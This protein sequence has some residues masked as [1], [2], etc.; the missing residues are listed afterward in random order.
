MKYTFF[1]YAGTG[2][3]TASAVHYLKSQN[4]IYHQ[5][6]ENQIRNKSIQQRNPTMGYEREREYSERRN[7]W[8]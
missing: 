6:Q 2:V 1:Y 4:E 8:I 3:Y 7:S 5:F